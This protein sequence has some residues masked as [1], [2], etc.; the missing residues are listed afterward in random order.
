M[1]GLA[2]ISTCLADQVLRIAVVDTQGAAVAGAAVIVS[3]QATR[4]TDSAGLLEVE[5]STPT[6]I[7]V[8]APGFMVESRRFQTWPEE[9]VLITL[10]PA[11]LYETVDVV[12][13]RDELE[14]GPAD[15]SAIEIDQTGARTV[16]DAV[17]KLVPSAF[18][19]RRGVMGYGIS[20]SGT[21]QVTVRGVGNSPNTGVLVVIDGRP[22]YMGM[23]GHP[24]PDFYSLP[25]AETVSVTKGPA[26]VLYG[27]NAMGGA[28]NIKPARPVEGLHTE[29]SASLGSYSTGQYRLKHGGGYPKWFYNVTAGADHTNGHRP[30]SHFRNQDGTVA[31]GYNLSDLWR[32]SLRGRYGHFVVED[33]GNV[34]SGPGPWASVGRGGFSWNL[35]DQSNRIWGNTRLFGSWGHHHIDDGWRSNDR[36][37]GVRTHQ[38]FL[39]SPVLLFDAGG[40]FADYGG[41]GWNVNSGVDYGDH[42]GRSG[43]GFGRLHWSPAHHVRLNT[44]LRYE[45]NS[46]FGG[47]A[48][49]EFGATFGLCQSCS[50]N[51][52]VSRGFRNPTI[53]ELYLFP[54]PNPDLEPEHMWNYQA[55]LA[56]Q[57]SRRFSTSLTGYYAD[58]DSVIVVTGRFP[59]LE[60]LNGG[61]TLNRGF[62]GSLRWKLQRRV[63]VSGGYAYLRST[64]LLPYVP[65]HKA[66]Y[67]AEID[68]RRAY[69]H[70]GGMTVGSRWADNSKTTELEGYTTPAFKLMIPV[71]DRLTV[72]GT[73]DN[74]FNQ[75]Y[76]VITGYPMPGVNAAGGFTLKL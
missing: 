11:P 48:V 40:D 74:L 2:V 26:S 68:L 59:N 70:I 35:E 75:D 14:V 64:N 57:P 55:T 31:V 32:T 12:V 8:S 1:F 13:K 67:T 21:G 24:L 17:D 15:V 52:S 39:L 76:Q 19:T 46:I 10:R 36:T 6:V 49:P 45:H 65:R 56:L 54:A 4:W 71:S 23:M 28:I 60:L 44:G 53:R 9:G 62:D 22:D 63:S 33:P 72:F 69:F 5:A 43:A 47:I 30:S 41:Q 25:D 66:T 50:V 58:L 3:D 42:I 29:L 18:V 73:V 27:T 20:G 34:G 16:F 51:L 61:R 7:R 37:V 38:N